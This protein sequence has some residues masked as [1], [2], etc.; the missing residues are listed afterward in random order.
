MR[1]RAGLYAGSGAAAIAT[2]TLLSQELLPSFGLRVWVTVGLTAAAGLIVILIGAWRAQA[3]DRAAERELDALLDAA[4][5]CWPPRAAGALSP[6]DLGAHPTGDHPP[7][8][9]PAGGPPDVLPTY[10]PRTVDEALAD[11]LAKADVVVVYGPSRAGKTRS[12]YE[13]LLAARPTAKLL[14]PE[15]AD[16]LRTTL[17]HVADLPR[18][19]GEP[20]VLWLDGVER[21]LAGLDL[22]VLDRLAA[23]GTRVQLIATIGEDELEALL[24]EPED[25]DLH[26]DG[27]RARRLL[28]RAR[29]VRVPTPDAEEESAAA[30]AAQ[31]GT[32]RARLP[33]GWWPTPRPVLDTPKRD[34]M[35]SLPV[36]L[37]LSLLVGCLAA[38]AV[39]ALDQGLEEPPDIAQQ[40]ADLESAGPACEDASASPTDVEKIDDDTVVALAVH[41]GICG[42]PDEL[43]LYRRSSDRLL[44]LT[45]LRL[46]A[47]GPRRTLACV[48]DSRADPC[49]VGVEGAGRILVGTFDDPRTRQAHPFAVHPV[50]DRLNLASLSPRPPDVSGGLD[51]ETLDK[52]RSA[53]PLR[54]DGGEHDDGACQPSDRCVM[55]HGAQAWAVFS[56]RTERPAVLVAGHLAN[57]SVPEAPRVLHLRA[58][59]VVSD[60]EVPAVHERCWI[61]KRGIRVRLVAKVSSGAEASADLASR[62]QALLKRPGS[63]VVC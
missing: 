26:P 28:A 24:H 17:A 61:F 44:R 45:T 39:Y 9:E 25:G 62:W 13:A 50:E 41:R 47:D 4:H 19:V 7:Q 35:P 55:S 56:K 30:A 59:R 58:W 53:T 23:D 16:G 12:A 8:A 37:F 57:G 21:F 3:N 11:A 36:G 14:V 49:A 40:V 29:A 10:V 46:P 51:P 33:D 27:R 38:T 34:W 2:A 22:D 31:T 5:A 63:S 54:L 18:I 60:G 43:R 52:N 6:Y 32:L 1:S 20:L 42:R 15:D 48:G